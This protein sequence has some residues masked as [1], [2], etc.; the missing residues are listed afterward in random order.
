MSKRKRDDSPDLGQMTTQQKMQYMH[1]NTDVRKPPRAKKDP[2][3][4]HRMIASIG[5]Y[6]LSYLLLLAEIFIMVVLNQPVGWDIWFKE[7][8]PSVLFLIVSVFLLFVIIFFYFFFEDRETLLSISNTFLIFALTLLCSAVCYLFGRYVSPYI[9]PFALFSLLILFLFNRR[10]AIFLNFI[11]TFL[12][13]VIDMYTNNNVGAANEVYSTLMLSFASGT[14]AVFFAGNVKTRSGLVFTGVILALPTSIVVA[15]LNVAS[16]GDPWLYLTNIGYGMLGSIISAVLALALLPVFEAIFNKLTVFRLRELTS[17]NAP[18]L[19]RLKKEAPGTFNHSLIVAQLSEAC[20]VAI[21]ENAELARAAAYY[22]DVGKL[23]DPQCFTENQSDYNV[24]NEL[25]PELS[26]DII[27]SHAQ[28]GYQLLIYNHLPKAIADV[29]LEHHGTL[30]IKYFFNKAFRIT[31][32]EAK[33]ANY[34]YF[35]PT[36]QTKISAIVMIADG[37]EAA[38]RALKDHSPENVEKTVRTIIEERMDLG[39]FAACDITMRDLTTIKQT[40]VETLSGVHHH[41]V[42]YPSIR[43]KRDMSVDEK[44]E[45]QD[46]QDKK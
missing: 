15:L 41:R 11:F 24:H 45:K 10:K 9:R 23:K 14:L 4:K 28:D 37:A 13:F 18:L 12:T 46:K 3:K 20:A 17:T 1:D 38:T 42:E 40:L 7:N 35:G 21:G 19:N 25:T 2:R 39:Q 31:G 22:H 8:V 29:A 5:I 16:M 33:I 30:P 44:A 6:V 26:A 36:P 43:I 27:R 34:S 32:G